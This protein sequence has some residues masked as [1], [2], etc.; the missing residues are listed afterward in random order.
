MKIRQ[1]LPRVIGKLKFKESLDWFSEASRLPLRGVASLR[2]IFSK[3]LVEERIFPENS[4]EKTIPKEVS[5]KNVSFTFAAISLSALVARADGAVSKEEYLAF[6]DSFPLTGGICS[7]IR[8]LFLLACQSEVP[9]TVHVQQIKTLFPQ[10]KELFI[11][12]MDRL[13]RIAI[14]DKPLSRVEERLLAR[15]SHSL[16]LSPSEYSSL[17]DRYSRPLA[18]HIV[19]GV[20]KRSPKT[21]IKQ[22]YHALMKRYHP[23][24]YASIPTSPEVQMLLTLKTAEISKAYEKLSKKAA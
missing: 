21:I 7:K 8:Q 16:G 9:F 23:D 2:Y 5:F 24:R 11:S 19:L 4:I 20:E 10:Q 12:L 6:R 18:P 3:E 13:F 14:A 17:Y 15:I 1:S 22:Q